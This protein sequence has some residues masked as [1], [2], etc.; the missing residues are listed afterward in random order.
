K[1]YIHK[2]IK[3]FSFKI[4]TI[5]FII[6]FYAVIL[7][8]LTMALINV[9]YIGILSIPLVIL[10]AVFYNH[11]GG[12]SSSIFVS[13]L[14]IISM[15][16][17]N[18]DNYLM[19]LFSL[20]LTFLIGGGLGAFMN[21][22]KEQKEKIDEERNLIYYLMQLQLMIKKEMEMKEYIIDNAALGIFCLTPEGELTYVNQTTSEWLGYSRE[23]L[24]SKK[25]AD[26]D[27]NFKA[28]DRKKVWNRLKNEKNMEFESRHQTKEGKTFPVQITSHYVNLK[29]EEYEFAFVQDISKRKQ[30][31]RN[32]RERK[33]WLDALFENST[34]AIIM[35]DASFRIVDINN[36]FRE[37]FKF[38]LNNIKG[39]DL[40]E[41]LET[42][43]TNSVNR[44]LTKE[45]LAGHKVI[46]EGKRYDKYGNPIDVLIRG[47]PIS[48]EDEIVGIY[49]IY[50]NITERKKKERELRYL[51]YHDQLTDLYN[52]TYLEEKINELDNDSMIPISLLMIDVNGLKMINDTYG[53]Q[54]GDNLLL[55]VSDILRK[56]VSKIDIVGRW[57]GD[58]FLIILPGTDKEKGHEIVDEINKRCR[59]IETSKI[60]ISLGIGLSVKKDNKQDLIQVLN[61]AEENMYQNKLT[62]G[63]STKSNILE[64][65][66]KT[67]GAKS[68]ET[69]EHAWRINKLAVKL[70]KKIGLINSELNK[71]SLLATLHDIGKTTISEDI[72][73]KPGKLNE[74][75]WEIIKKHPEKGY[76]IASA[77]DEFAHIAELILSH[78][79]RWDGNGYPRGL[80]GREIPLLAR[81]ITI[82][83]AYDVMTNGRPYKDVMSKEEALEEIER[84]AGSQFD[85]EL[86]EVFVRLMREE[87]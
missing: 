29:G 12:L 49:G 43:K 78:H 19:I 73:L 62:A 71:L 7:T 6:Y 50:E 72:L 75:E 21:S 40:D 23:E 17:N 55:Q 70:G 47:I 69:E 52:R 82:V 56:T 57:A 38:K 14:I 64:S 45:V 66:L 65:L 28:E 36:K 48:I 25:V 34:A 3:I 53:H 81:I 1:N 10:S 20:M 87:E 74:K 84:C 27:P 22:F 16:I 86:A 80:T 11:K 9:H 44:N 24:I 33:L 77:T 76:R 85:P 5:L 58:E 18:S 37:L 46:T 61:E 39:K 54:A 8:V 30:R 2:D 68:H 63:R 26:I 32:L 67:L 79:E 13:S 31:E 4:N 51:S 35:A 60:P 83:D 41:V 59:E 42:G 15:I